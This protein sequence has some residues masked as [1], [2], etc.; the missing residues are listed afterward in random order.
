MTDLTVP[1]SGSSVRW[2]GKKDTGIAGDTITPGMPLYKD[3]TDNNDLKPADADVLASS[4]FA[5]FALNSAVHGQPVEFGYGEGTLTV[6]GTGVSVGATY[7]VSTGAGGI[8]PEA[9]LSTGDFMTF[10]GFGATTSTIK[11]APYS[12]QVTHV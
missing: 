4:I 11:C 10:L 7:V 6:G 9:D 1:T 2:S 12:S 3:T 8:A 5:G